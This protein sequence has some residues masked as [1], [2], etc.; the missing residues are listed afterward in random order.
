M[1]CIRC[2]RED[3]VYAHG[4]CMNCYQSLRIINS[5]D[6]QKKKQMWRKSNLPHCREYMN[7]YWKDNPDQY[8]K[9]KKRSREY[10]RRR[11]EEVRS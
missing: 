4:L 1:K 8:E 10:Q 9:Q 2:K 3:K 7:K 6:A 11:R 5:P